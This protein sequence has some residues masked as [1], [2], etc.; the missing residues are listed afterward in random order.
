MLFWLIIRPN[1]LNQQE[2]SDERNEDNA[3]NYHI[4]ERDTQ[5]SSVIQDQCKINCIQLFLVMLVQSD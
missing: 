3:V 2:L 4:K 5:S 1:R